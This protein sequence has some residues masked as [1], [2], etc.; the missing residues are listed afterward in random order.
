MNDHPLISL[1]IP[2]RE[3]A[4]TLF[5]TLRT[6]VEQDERDCEILVCDNA[7]SDRTRT[8]VEAFADPRLRY[9]N[10]G[11]RL[12]MSENWNYAMQHVRGQYVM[13][14]GDDDGVMPGALTRLRLLIESRPAKIYFWQVSEYY[15]PIDDL[16][17]VISH[18][19][20]LSR[21]RDVDLAPLAKFAVRWGTW[22][23]SKLPLGYHSAVA[24]ELLDAMLSRTGKVFHSTNPDVFMAFALPPLCS[25]AIDTGES[26]TVHGCS[27]KANAGA[28][29]A[30]DGRTVF[31][32]FVDEYEHYR[33]HPTLHPS[34]P[35]KINMYG[36]SALKAID[37]FP[38]FYHGTPFNYSAMY[39]FAHRIVGSFSI[40]EILAMR[41]EIRQRQPFSALRFLAYCVLHELMEWRIMLRRKLVGSRYRPSAADMPRDIYAMV[42][43]L[44]R[45][46]PRLS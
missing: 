4:E 27:A 30:A 42:H 25:H 38:D 26:Y 15:W 45:A 16:P 17:P 46:Q 36:D 18:V 32:K 43:Y 12:P 28:R 8:V 34:I 44:M 23:Y 13:I 2:T 7:S 10:P 35:F 21:P 11:R 5:H 39:A 40:R 19:A 3:R 29:L 31:Q 24:R 1:V 33:L 41:R 20:P 37:L 9:I 14:I 22:R 6:A